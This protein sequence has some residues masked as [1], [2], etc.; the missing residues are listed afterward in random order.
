MKRSEINRWV[1]EAEAVFARSNMRLPP[2]CGFSAE[3]WGSLGVEW[4]EVV[5]RGLGWDLTDMGS[6][7]F[8]RTGLVLLTLRNGEPGDAP[9]RKNYAEKLMLSLPGQVMPA[10]YHAYKME[11]IIVRAGGRLV[12]RLWNATVAGKL[13]ESSEV[14]VVTDGQERRVE[15]GGRVVLSA[16]ESITLPPRLYHEFHGH[17]EDEACVMGEVSK[18]NDDHTDNFF[19]RALPR[20]PVIEEDEAPHRLLVGDY[21]RWYRH[22]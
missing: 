21:R 19:L 18:A 13:D 17:P 16:G 2:F 4:R 7:D 14:T 9:G 5:E 8:L 6:G 3:K 12:I 10:H 11:D 22:V 1:R 15:A 20:F